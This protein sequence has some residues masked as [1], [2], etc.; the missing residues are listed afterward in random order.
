[1]LLNSPLAFVD[2]ETTGMSARK[3]KIIEIGIHRVENSKLV[4]SFETLINPGVALDP[5]IT[6]LTGITDGDL[7][8]A[9]GFKQAAPE[10]VEIMEGCI[11]AAHSAD[12]DYSFLKAEFTRC[13]IKFAPKKLCTV[14]L[15]R[16]LYP[17]HQRHSLDHI[18]KRGGFKI[19]NRHRA[20]DDA[21]VLWQFYQELFDQFDLKTIEKAFALQLA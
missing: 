5:F 6:E 17:E 9:P 20:S 19:S 2:I 7:I 12:F 10:L 14:K 21:H 1:M 15:S 3:G 8:G 18:I 4:S 11:F 13:K 16:A